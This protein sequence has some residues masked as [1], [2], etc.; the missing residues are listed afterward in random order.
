MTLIYESSHTGLADSFARLEKESEETFVVSL[1][2]GTE[3]LE[4]HFWKS[5]NSAIA[6]YVNICATFELS[7][8]IKN[9]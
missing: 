2:M 1:M 6:D 8:L 4:S 9:L 3:V 7:P 5:I